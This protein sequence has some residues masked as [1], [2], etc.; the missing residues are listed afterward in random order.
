[1]RSLRVVVASV[2][3][4]NAV[5]VPATEVQSPVEHLGTKNFNTILGSAREP[6]FGSLPPSSPESVPLRRGSSN[7]GLL[8]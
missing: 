7:A 3:S 5:E 8:G 6:G 2:A 4:K 1:M